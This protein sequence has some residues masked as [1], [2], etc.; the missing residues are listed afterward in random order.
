MAIVLQLSLCPYELQGS[1]VCVDDR[2]LPHNVMLPLA[3]GLHNGI[4]FFVVSGILLDCVRKSHSSK[5]LD[6][7]AE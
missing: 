5:P 1:M 4:H 3:A 6:A 7:H 2:F